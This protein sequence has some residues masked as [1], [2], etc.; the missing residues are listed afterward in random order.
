MNHDNNE[1]FCILSILL[2]DVDMEN[3]E[4]TSFWYIIYLI[5]RN[6]LL[7]SFLVI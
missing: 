7:T 1:A 6:M 3:Q 2:L 4:K 5:V